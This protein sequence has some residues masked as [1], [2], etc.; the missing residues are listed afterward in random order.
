MVSVWY[1]VCSGKCVRL[2]P[3]LTGLALT[4]LAKAQVQRLVDTIES[5]VAY[6]CLEA[7]P[8]V[9]NTAANAT[10]PRQAGPVQRLLADPSLDALFGTKGGGEPSGSTKALALVRGVLA[11]SSGELE[12]V[13]TGVVPPREEG[14]PGQPLLILRARLQ[15]AEADSLQLALDGNELAA[16]N[17]RLGGQSTY[18]LRSEQKAE[19]PGQ[20]V[21][22]ALV[23][24]DLL[25]GNDTSAM[26]EVL[27]SP[28]RGTAATNDRAVLST[29]PRFLAMRQRL[30][31]APGALWMYGDWQRLN[32]R[33]ESAVD[34]VPGWLIHS[35]GLGDARAVMA[36]VASAQADF[37]A[38]LLLDFDAAA[39]PARPAGRH[40]PE[41]RGPERRGPVNEPASSG[42]DG[43][44]AAMQP[45]SART[46]VPE[47]PAG[48]LGGVVLSVD[49]ASLAGRSHEG[50]HL[51]EHLHHA[52]DKYGLDFDR[53]VLSRL[54]SRGTLQLHV[55]RGT[56]AAQV[57]AA[58][59]N[60]IYSMHTKNKKAAADLFA[61]LRRVCEPAGLGVLVTKDVKETGRER[62]VVELLEL[63]ERGTSTFLVA[64]EDTLLLAADA[65]TLVTVVDDLRRSGRPKARRSE[66]TATAISSIG[67]ENVAG[68]FDVDLQP[69]F[70]RIASAFASSG[71]RV[72]LS[73]LPKRH[74]GYLDVQRRE[75]GTLVR[76]RV[77][78]SR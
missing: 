4:S 33:L 62:R 73:T 68:L 77:L 69:L 59:V 5:P 8:A 23:G 76:V 35:S 9:V 14:R 42:I 43:W 36:S 20:E 22:L 17:R 63:R 46:L 70:D 21:E 61:D 31:I 67:G 16:P 57:E 19:A 51:L 26:R 7:M 24:A 11:R 15:R 25:V 32:Q 40:G 30:P 41:R 39:A 49:L 55:A 53:N 58:Q 74:I 38:T 72:D 29:Q 2:L 34:G 3:V 60:A 65:D 28:A 27:E 48:G 54:G 50:A 52:F 13:L 1:R 45:T 75:A 78:S 47:L 10:A 71:A 66:A 64:H 12:L 6:L 18:K 56:E 37:T 44:F